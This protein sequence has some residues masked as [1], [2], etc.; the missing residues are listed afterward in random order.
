M[1]RPQSPDSSDEDEGESE[2]ESVPKQA[3]RKLGGVDI[4]ASDIDIYPNTICCNQGRYAPPSPPFP[5]H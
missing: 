3:E 4:E 1:R 5:L 2:S